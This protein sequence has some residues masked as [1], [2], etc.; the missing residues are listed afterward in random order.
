[1]PS[2]V[3]LGLPKEPVIVPPPQTFCR[4]GAG[5]SKH[6]VETSPQASKSVVDVLTNQYRQTSEE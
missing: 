1:M 4:P 2:D 3:D 5:S 6:R